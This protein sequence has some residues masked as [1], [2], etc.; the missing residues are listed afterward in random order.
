VRKPGLASYSFANSEEDRPLQWLQYCLQCQG[1]ELHDVMVLDLL[2]MITDEWLEKSDEKTRE[3]FIKEV[4]NF[5]VHV[6]Q[7]IKPSIIISANH[8][9]LL[10]GIIVVIGAP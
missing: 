5:V 9:P 3:G 1:L 7:T 8:F 6:L 4:C 2:P 10:A